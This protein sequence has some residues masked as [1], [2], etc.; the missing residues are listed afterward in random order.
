MNAKDFIRWGGIGG[1]TTRGRR[2]MIF[3]PSPSARGEFPRIR[4]A[5]LPRQRAMIS[6]IRSGCKGVSYH[7]WLTA[8]PTSAARPGGPPGSPRRASQLSYWAASAG[9]TISTAR[10]KT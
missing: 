8:G 4:I 9:M 5:F 3:A 10:A 1:E 6:T 7:E 2:S